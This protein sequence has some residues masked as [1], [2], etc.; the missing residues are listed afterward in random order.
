[1][2][3]VLNVKEAGAWKCMNF[4]GNDVHVKDGGVWVVPTTV[5]VKN[6]G[7]WVTVWPST[8]TASTTANASTVVAAEATTAQPQLTS[9]TATGAE[10]TG[11]SSSEGE[12]VRFSD[13]NWSPTT[14]V[15][16]TRGAV[17]TI[18]VTFRAYQDR[19]PPVGRENTIRVRAKLGTGT[20]KESGPLTTGSYDSISLTGTPAAWGLTDEEAGNLH[21]TDAQLRVTPKYDNA[22]LGSDTTVIVD[23]F[24]VQL[25][26]YYN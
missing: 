5:R 15:G 20:Y 6:G 12:G 14:T 16:F 26:Y 3:A 7:V 19:D 2:S 24:K 13:F 21:L 18:T 22:T 8:S 4:N 9:Y 11:R 1:M 25:E 17:K 23:T 10:W